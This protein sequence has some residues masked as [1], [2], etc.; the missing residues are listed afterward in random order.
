M[1]HVSFTNYL[2]SRIENSAEKNILS[3]KMNLNKLKNLQSNLN[4]DLYPDTRYKN[5][6]MF[7]LLNPKLKNE[8]EKFLD[9]FVE[10][11]NFN[12]RLILKKEEGVNQKINKDLEKLA[13]IRPNLRTTAN[14]LFDKFYS[15][16]AENQRRDYKTQL[17]TNIMP[18][19]TNDLVISEVDAK[20]REKAK[21]GNCKI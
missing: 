7:E 9:K 11:L 3:N 13:E 2:L 16:V 12:K 1:A 5:F 6:Q 15:G 21:R 4:S 10:D 19:Y 20:L 18:K 8:F 14:Q 17:L